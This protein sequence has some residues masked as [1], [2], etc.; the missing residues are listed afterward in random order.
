MSERQARNKI[1]RIR[2]DPTM[3]KLGVGEESKTRKEKRN[4]FKREH[5][6]FVVVVDI[7]F[8][9]IFFH[10]HIKKEKW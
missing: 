8:H 2:P 1:S 5:V 6:M 3:Q 7:V 9:T 10:L 4:F